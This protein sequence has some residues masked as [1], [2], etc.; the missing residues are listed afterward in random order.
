MRKIVFI[1]S[2]LLYFLNSYSQDRDR[3]SIELNGDYYHYFRGKNISNNFNIGSSLLF[4][5][6]LNDVKISVG[7]HY[8][9]KSYNSPGGAFLAIKRRRH[10]LKYLNIPILANIEFSSQP[11]ITSKLLLGFNFIQLI[12]YRIKTFYLSGKNLQEKGLLNNSNLGL[13]FTLGTT[14]TKSLG[15]RYLINLSTFSNFKLNPEH[16]DARQNYKNRPE[17]KI[18]IGFRIGLEYLII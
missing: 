14:F 15:D 5:Q 6:Y 2:F 11:S 13:N 9:K 12:D 1:L 10:N 8:L 7:A 16:Y 4:S 17:D 18:S 3:I